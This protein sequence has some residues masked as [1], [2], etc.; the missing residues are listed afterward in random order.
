MLGT[1]TGVCLVGKDELGISVSVAKPGTDGALLK[2]MVAL[3]ALLKIHIFDYLKDSV[4]CNAV[5][6]DCVSNFTQKLHPNNILETLQ[7]A[8][9][10]VQH[11]CGCH[12]D[13]QNGT[14]P[15]FLPVITF[16]PIVD[17]HTKANVS[18]LFDD[19][20]TTL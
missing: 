19:Y 14:H 3:S 18:M 13:S 12:D 8:I 6:F 2:A 10:N 20:N 4:H 11:P 1:L 5:N 7:A 9:S 17:L 16:S 15:H